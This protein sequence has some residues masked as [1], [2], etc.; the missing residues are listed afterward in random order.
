MKKICPKTKS[1]KHM[2]ELDLLHSE[3]VGTNQKIHHD[4][5]F[6]GGY[7][8]W[9]DIYKYYLYPIC[10]FCGYVDDTKPVIEENQVYRSNN[11][12]SEY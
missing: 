1:G 12:N 9:E 5:F 11:S 6:G 4:G 8:S 3:Q 10:R 7:D 2:Y